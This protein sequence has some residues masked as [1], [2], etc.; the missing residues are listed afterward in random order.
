MIDMTC[1]SC[2]RAGRVPRDKIN[3]RLVCKKCN[4][5][6]HLTPQGVAI[7]GE[8][9]AV[10]AG[11]AARASREGGRS[12]SEKADWRD[13]MPEGGLTIS[14]RGVMIG[15]AAVLILGSLY[16]YMN[17]PSET[18]EDKTKEVGY[19]LAGNDLGVI[20]GL[21]SS[22]TTADAESWARGVHDLL[23]RKRA[24]W[25]NKEVR[26]QANVIEQNRR[27]SRGESMIV[28]YPNA[29]TTRNNEISTEADLGGPMS[30]NAVMISVY[31]SLDSL[32]KWHVDGAGCL[33]ALAMSQ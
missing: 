22:G 30:K 33:K 15:G 4:R 18:L 26:T 24:S 16:L 25:T 29:A 17:M 13:M 9:P 32:G 1:P 19:A 31:W 6:F 7:L 11:A 3:M 5:V 20:R 21:A 28:L 2:G 8:P 23:E 14:R 27:L 12:E 10:K